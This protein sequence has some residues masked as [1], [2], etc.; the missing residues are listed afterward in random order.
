MVRTAA[1]RLPILKS[2][3][4]TPELNVPAVGR[5]EEVS[6]VLLGVAVETLVL[7]I[8]E[9]LWTEVV[10]RGELYCILISAKD[11]LKIGRY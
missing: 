5:E 11:A 3:R 2:R 9:L 10:D 4:D 6:V 1:T 7:T 8:K